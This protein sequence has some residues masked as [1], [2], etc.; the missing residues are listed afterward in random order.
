MITRPVVFWSGQ[1]LGK[2]IEIVRSHKWLR[3]VDTLNNT[4]LS[5]IEVYILR[6]NRFFIAFVE[7][8][9]FITP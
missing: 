1:V 4:P 2:R 3:K 8:N 7:I 9:F 6:N 5:I